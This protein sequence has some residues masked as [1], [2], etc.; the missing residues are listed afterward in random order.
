MEKLYKPG[1]FV[2][3]GGI[4]C[5]ASKPTIDMCCECSF[6]DAYGCDYVEECMKKLEEFSYPI[7]VIPVIIE[8][9]R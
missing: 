2:S 1:Q 7:P 8:R 6:C 3:I 9:K 4:L 5:R